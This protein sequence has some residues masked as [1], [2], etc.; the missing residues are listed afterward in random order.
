MLAGMVSSKGTGW[1]CAR[2]KRGA[3]TATHRT[4][5]GR[6]LIEIRFWEYNGAVGTLHWTADEDRLLGTMPD[7]NLAQR[8]GRSPRTII[9]RRRKL[10]LAPFRPPARHWSW[11]EEELLGTMPDRRL[12]RRLNR[13]VQSVAARR[14]A[15]HL[16]IL[17]SKI[18]EW[19][20]V[21][22]KLLS[23]RPDAQVA[24]LLGIS[25]LAVQHRRLRLGISRP[26]RDYVR[27]R[28][29]QPGEDALLGTASDSEV[30]R[31][32]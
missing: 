23:E 14:R 10:R 19:T 22:D 1:P 9:M 4:W 13:S 3:G 21:D 24:M 12:A 16:P 5:R 11:A 28:P 6:R 26:G 17:H 8:L 2:R 29:W 18:Y 30:A 31:R 7:R 25:R 20:P 15:R 27:L 32:L